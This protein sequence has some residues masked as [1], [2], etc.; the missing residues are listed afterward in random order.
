MILW[1][2]TFRKLI[3]SYTCRPS[4]SSLPESLFPFC[5]FWP[6]MSC[7]W[8]WTWLFWHSQPYLEFEIPDIF[9]NDVFSRKNWLDYNPVGYLVWIIDSGYLIFARLQVDFQLCITFPVS[10]YLMNLAVNLEFDCL[11]L[12]YG[13]SGW[14][15]VESTSLPPSV[16]LK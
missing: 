9:S 8:T 11:T 7:P 16:W 10:F 1:C 15:I 5:W 14:C 4:D 6:C 12:T 13:I 3:L 2:L